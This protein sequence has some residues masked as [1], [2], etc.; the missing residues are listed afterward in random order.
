MAERLFGFKVGARQWIGV[1]MTAVGLFLLVVTLP[2]SSG[3]HSSYSLA[4][5]I[6]FEAAMLVIGA[7]LITGPRFGAPDHHH[8]VMLGGAAGVL[9]GVSDV[10]IKALTG[11][12]R[13]RPGASSSRPGSSSPSSARSSPSTPRPAACRTARP[14]RSSPRPRPPPTSPASPAASSSSATRCP[15]TSLG[16]VVQIFAF[17]MVVVAALVTPPPVRAAAG[18]TGAD[19][20]GVTALGELTVGTRPPAGCSRTTCLQQHARDLL[21]VVPGRD[22]AA[23]VSVT[24]RASG[25]SRRARA[26]WRE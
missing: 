26:L 18:R 13:R 9:F 17:T 15:P 5:M 24:W 22:V 1:G 7:L 2:A 21:R 4:G 8:G 19:G 23:A 20:S 3:A 6:A 14:S 11:S 12:R 25:S 16:I 10:A